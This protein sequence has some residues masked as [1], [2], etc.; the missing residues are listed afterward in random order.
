VTPFEYVVVLISIVLGLAA[1]RLLTGIGE[2]IE[3][4]D[5]KTYWV[6]LLWVLNTFLYI[7]MIW[8]II[9]RWRNTQQWTFYHFLF[10]L[11]GPTVLYLLTVLL[12]PDGN[13][14]DYRAHYYAWRR[15]FFL[16]FALLAPL[17]LIDTLLK[18]SQHFRELGWRYVG[19]LMF[20]W[21]LCVLAALTSN[22][23][24]HAVFSI[25]YLV[26]L[27]TWITFGLRILV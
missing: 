19:T 8:W 14:R 4:R 27:L 20:G 7:V 16:I 18:G 2:M 15:P 9:Y 25:F 21:M 23:R 10:L 17:D 11:L 26:Y 13:Q 22:P 24:F 3:T 5:R 6:H 1:T 12:F